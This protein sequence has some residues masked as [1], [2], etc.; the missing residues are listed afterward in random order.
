MTWARYTDTSIIFYDDLD[1]VA[2]TLPISATSNEVAAAF[3]TIDQADQEPDWER[4]K[5][6]AMASSTFT[7]I[8]TAIP[9]QSCAYLTT[10]LVVAEMGQLGLFKWAWSEIVHQAGVPPD[11]TAGFAGIASACHLPAEFVATLHPA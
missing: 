2:A 10:A 5:R 9:P 3:R 8:T 7:A 6:I 4:F 11:V 1:D